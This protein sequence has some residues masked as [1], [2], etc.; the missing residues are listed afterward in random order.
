MTD[1]AYICV[2]VWCH[3]YTSIHVSMEV[4]TVYILYHW[5]DISYICICE[6]MCTVTYTVWCDICL[7]VYYIYT[8]ICHTVSVYTMYM[9]C[10][11]HSM[12]VQVHTEVYILT[13]T[14][15][16]IYSH[17]LTLCIYQTDIW[18]ITMCTHH[19]IVYSY[20]SPICVHVYDSVYIC[21]I[22]M[23]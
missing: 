10:S 13:Y 18:Y 16:Y 6:Y 22:R 4:Y 21:H 2:Y 5:H 14:C 1:M 23:M 7:H 19:Y 15:I 11:Q 8:Y 9:T 20:D 12:Y 3:V 17:I